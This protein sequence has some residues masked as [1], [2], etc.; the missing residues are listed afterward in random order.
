MKQIIYGLKVAWGFY[1][2]FLF[3]FFFLLFYPVLIVLLSTPKLY[4]AANNL[5]RLWAAIILSC[6]GMLWRI[7]Y[8]SK[9]RHPHGVIFC[10]NHFSYL[11][12]P[13]AMLCCH[14]NIR[15][16]AKMELGNIPIFKIFFR[17]I[18]IPVNRGNRAEA[19]KA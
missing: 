14:G 15:F 16:M 10:P 5:R 19:Y 17:T 1:Y 6:S 4:G 7:T 9:D 12:I 2:F 8:E 11:D 3:I 13:T 18:D